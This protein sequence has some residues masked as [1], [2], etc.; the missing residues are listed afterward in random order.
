MGNKGRKEMVLNTLISPSIRSSPACVW[1]P[2]WKL[3]GTEN[4]AHSLWAQSRAEE[5]IYIPLFNWEK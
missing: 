3:G 1:E 4:A 5:H 2:N